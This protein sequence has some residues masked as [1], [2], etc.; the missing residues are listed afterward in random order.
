MTNPPVKKNDL[1]DRLAGDLRPVRR[2]P[3]GAVVT[4]W[5]LLGWSFVCLVT[6]ATGD[7]RPGVIGQLQASP[8]FVLECG[9]GF[10]VGIVLYRFAVLLAVPGA[11]SARRA[12]G[13]SVA[14]L[15]AWFGVY[16]YG[17][18][19]PALEPSMV[20]KRPHC[21]VETFVFSSVPLVVGF[22]LVV[23]RLPL[24]RGWT[25]ALVGSAAASIPATIMQIACMYD[26]KHIL[27]FH[28]GPVLI[29]GSVGAAAGWLGF[30]RP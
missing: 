22:W 15:S 1:I 6:F 14:L 18:V 11:T 8:R 3:T 21:F 2:F 7:L 26:P 17:L 23:R 28:L 24:A 19:D 16:L 20:G 5:L 4:L 25:G 13:I 9:L 27:Q 30:R 12:A 29:V 10:V